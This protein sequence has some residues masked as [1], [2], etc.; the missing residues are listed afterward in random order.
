GRWRIRWEEAPANAAAGGLVLCVSHSHEYRGD[1]GGRDLPSGCARRVS[2]AGQVDRVK[3]GPLYP[4]GVWA[5][6]GAVLLGQGVSRAPVFG[7]QYGYRR[8]SVSLV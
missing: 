2:Q 8:G 4:R 6:H 3:R 7:Q 1:V 5:N